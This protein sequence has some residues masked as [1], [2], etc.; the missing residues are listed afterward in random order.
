MRAFLIC[1]LTLFLLPAGVRGQGTGVNSRQ[2]TPNVVLIYADDLGYGDLGC[3]GSQQNVTRHLDRMAKEGA[4]LTSFYVAQAV[5]SASRAALLTGCYPN[6][7]GILG[8]LGPKSDIGI[9]DKETTI[10][11]MLKAKG[12]QTACFGKWHLG[13][14][15]QFLPIKHGFDVYYGL[16]YSNDM[17]PKHPNAKAGYPNLPLYDMD[18][19]VA[20]NPPQG[21]L[22]VD[23]TRRAVKFIEENKSSPFFVYLAHSMPHV[24]LHVSQMNARYGGSAGLYSQVITEIDQSVGSILGTLRSLGLDKNTLVIFTSDNGPWLSYGDHAGSSGGFREGK[25]TTFEGG[26]RVPFIAYWPGKIPAGLVS[27]EPCMTIDML[28]TLAHLTG[29]KLPELKI[30]GLNI[31]PVL[32]KQD[33]KSPHEA[34][35]FYWNRELQAVRLGPWKLHLPHNYASLKGPP[36][37]DGKPGQYEQKRLPLSLFHLENDPGEKENLV[38]KVPD[39]LKGSLMNM[40]NTARQELGDSLTMKEGTGV[41]PSGRIAP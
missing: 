36:G 32:S 31:W 26:V 2:D 17:W 40:A 35:Y 27:K 5:C 10:A 13:H 16:P 18:K 1:N 22:T 6:R 23:Y 25:G 30:D 19:I 41:R 8:A 14:H 4:R 15:E 39:Q 3:Y 34:L 28:P 21:E 38:D 7:I 9:S 24:P 33:A 12:Y 37:K 29:A 20:L 11:Q